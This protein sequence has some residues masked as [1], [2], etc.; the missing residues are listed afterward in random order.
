MAIIFMDGFDHYGTGTTGKT[1]M[2][3][4]Y[5]VYS[6]ATI[7]KPQTYAARSGL[8]GLEQPDF[9][10]SFGTNLHTVGVGCSLF[11]SDLPTTNTMDGFTFRDPNGWPLCSIS[12]SNSQEIILE[13]TYNEVGRGSPGQF[14]A[15]DWYH[16]E[17]KFTANGA[18]SSIEVRINGVTAY[19]NNSFQCGTLIGAAYGSTATTSSSVSFNL[20]YYKWY[21]DD[22]FIW[23]TTG[24]YNNDFI[25]DRRVVTLYPDADTSVADWTPN[26][27][28]T[29]YTQIDD[30]AVDG[31]TTYVST[32]TVGHQSEYDLTAMPGNTWTINAIQT[33]TAAR[34]T[35]AGPGSMRTDIISN[36]TNGTGSTKTLGTS[37]AMRSDV[38][39]TDPNTGSAWT[40]SGVNAMK[41]RIVREA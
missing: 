20:D 36:G 5:G 26:S 28:S 40:L 39:Q 16:F 2:V 11:I 35:D 15:G 13:D 3:T 29:E 10:K 31:D 38:F 25:G 22:F 17:V 30:S 21:M 1:N 18:T 33:M 27:G 4:G 41:V 8:C 14:A 37:Y 12:F 32:N 24:S 9:T 19:Q 23:D 34:K 6:Q 7:G